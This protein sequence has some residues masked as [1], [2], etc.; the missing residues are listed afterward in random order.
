MDYT[1]QLYQLLSA[2]VTGTSTEAIRA[3]TST[4][5]K[6]FYGDAQCVPALVKIAAEVPEA[7]IRQLAAVEARKRVSRFWSDCGAEVQAGVRATL[8]SRVAVE[9]ESSAAHSIARVIAVIARS[10]VSEGKWPEL[11]PTLLQAGQSPEVAH[12]EIAV[13]TIFCILQ[14]TVLEDLDAYLADT[15]NLLSATLKDEASRAVRVTS[16]ETLGEIA[17]YL[18]PDDKALVRFFQDLLPS[19]VVVLEDAMTAGDE[20]AAAR[21]FGVFDSLLSSDAPVVTAHMESFVQFVVTA[22]ANT[23]LSDD[24]RMMA[25]NLLVLLPLYRRQRLIKLKLIEPV[26][27]L[28]LPV[29]CEEDGEEDEDDDSPA[30]IA[31]KCIHSFAMNL[32]PTH[33]FPL[34]S[35]SINQYAAD[36]TN[37]HAR[38][39]AMM[40]LTLIVDGCTDAIRPHAPHLV[41]MVLALMQD[42]EPRVRRSA[43]I[44]MSAL[45]EALESVV[46]MHARILPALFGL[47]QDLGNMDV[48]RNATN[49]LDSL[50]D[51]LGDDILPYINDLMTTLVQLLSVNDTKVRQVVA[52]A[53][54]SAANA[55]GPQF[56]QYFPHVVPLMLELMAIRSEDSSEMLLRG[57]AIDTMSAMAEAVGAEAFRPYLPRATELANESMNMHDQAKLKECAFCFFGVLSRTYK[58]EFAAFLP[59]L[60]PQLLASIAAQETFFGDDDDEDLGVHNPAAAAAGASANGAAAGAGEEDLMSEE[61]DDDEDEDEAMKVSSA[62]AEEKSTALDVLADLFESTETNFLPFLDQTMAAFLDNAEHYHDGVRKSLVLGMFKI[63]ATMHSLSNAAPWVAGLPAQVPVDQ[64]VSGMIVVVMTTIL[65]MLEEEDDR[66]VAAEICDSLQGALRMI[67]PALVQNEGHLDATCNLVISILEGKHLAQQDEDGEDMDADELAEY[68]GILIAAAG[69]VVGALA[70]ALG[71]VTFT[72][73]SQRFLVLLSKYFKPKSA[74]SERS[75]AIGTLADIALGMREGV[76]QWHK[77]LVNLFT[78]ALQDPESEVRSNGAYGLGLVAEHTAAAYDARAFLALLAP[79]AAASDLE[80]ERDNACGAM[81]RI[82]ARNDQWTTLADVIPGA[83]LANLPLRADFEENKPVAALLARIQQA[84]AAGAAPAATELVSAYAPQLVAIVAHYVHPEH[85]NETTVEARNE[86]VAA[87]HALGSSPLQ[88]TVQAAMVQLSPDLQSGLQMALAP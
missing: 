76:T 68:D 77:D 84:A 87:L 57:I 16:L 22:F 9:P 38:R 50:L 40:S 39:A 25:G 42:P 12:R 8:L 44:A 82:L 62:I 70:N 5:N 36:A 20:S 28:V 11:M 54:G 74:V 85:A 59:Q 35:A 10:D 66:V 83:L 73:L 17:E 47:M 55:A 48:L 23:Q 27:S 53:I 46:E 34:I 29:T 69:D 64:T 26:L 72:P 67:G 41:D 56:A 18:G 33:V 1:T 24:V 78:R 31:L 21:G 15:L 51:G 13:Y 81:A 65:K 61:E 63:L 32:P 45:T 30:R 71:P 37:P 88:A 14:A 43:C 19:M 4:L 3:A 75:M 80:Q 52:A 79:R 49:A 7:P 86:L 60:V 2:S 58:G 6:Q